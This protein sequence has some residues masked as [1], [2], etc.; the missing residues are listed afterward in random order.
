MKSKQVIAREL[1]KGLKDLKGLKIPEIR[2]HS[3]HSYYIYPMIL[4]V[5][6][7]GV[8][9]KIYKALK[10][11]GVQGLIDNYILLHLYPMYQKKIA[12]GSKKFPWS[13]SKKHILQKR[14]MSVAEN[15]QEKTFGITNS[16]L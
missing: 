7:L 9:E 12:Y 14:N 5:K 10:S 16:T 8:K 11:E 1:N 4:D 3:T 2:K 6:K 15:L 13:L